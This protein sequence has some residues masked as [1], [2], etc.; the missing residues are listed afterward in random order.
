MKLLVFLSFNFLVTLALAQGSIIEEIQFE[1]LKKTNLAFVKNIISTNNDSMLD[2]VVIENDIKKLNQLAGIA[3][4]TFRIESTETNKYKIV[5]GI[6]EQFTLI[7]VLNIWTSNYQLAIKTGLYQHNLLG[8]NISIG[9]FYQYNEFNSYGL[10]IKAPYLFSN[11]FGLEINYQNWSSLEPVYFKKFVADYK[12]NNHGLEVLAH[13]KVNYKHS[14]SAGLNRFNEKYQYIS[15]VDSLGL[16]EIP[17]S[18]DKRKLLFKV[19]YNYDN[20]NYK[21]YQ[22][23]GIKYLLY[24][25][26]VETLEGNEDSFLIGWNDFIF[27]SYAGS[28]GNFASRIRFGLS[29]N[30]DSPLAPFTLD[31]H[32]NIRGVGDKIDRGTGSI[33]WNVEYRHAFI[34]KRWLAVQAVV[35]VDAGTWRN[36]GGKLSDFTSSDNIRVYPGLGLRFIHKKIY[37]AIFRIDYGYG[38]TKYSSNGIVFGIGQYF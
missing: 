28:K 26:D 35:F 14:I 31:N 30:M 8:R 3:N 12:Y 22:I 23:S 32:V 37:N 16:K 20:L 36:P 2:S 13:F 17:N 27:Y 11:R 18:V 24:L 25:Q 9:G 38:I 6:E 15:G 4:A 29:T 5:Y 34:D 10:S 21:F 7:P 19:G 1:G 33:V